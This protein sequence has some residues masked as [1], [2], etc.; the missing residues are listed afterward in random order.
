M[1]DKERLLSKLDELD[2]YLEELRKIL[3]TNFKVYQTIP[4]KRGTERLLQLCIECVIDICQL[5][6]SGLRLGL[7]TDELDLFEKLLKHKILSPKTTSLLRKM[8]GFRNILA[9]DYGEV[10]DELVFETSSKRLGD[11]RVFKNEVL[12]YLRKNSP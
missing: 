4:I 7:P 1:V 2:G 12:K 10:D 6:V 3:P 5:L 8:K 9:H 11:F